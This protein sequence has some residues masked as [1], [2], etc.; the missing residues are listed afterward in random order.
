MA[1]KQV[2][3]YNLLLPIWLLWIFPQVWLIILPGNLLLDCAV[4]LLA[5]AALRCTA[6]KAVLRRVWWRVWLNGFLADAAGVAWMVLGMFAAAYGGD[7]WEEQL[8]AIAGSP[9]RTPLAL[10]WTLAGVAL[11]G[12]CIYFLDRHALGRCP[13]LSPRQPRLAAL[14]LAIATAPWLFLVPLY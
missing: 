10:V 14:A 6:K 13:E 2:R 7:W 8:A 4:L 11:A 5:L 12:V 3:L 1:K 9:F